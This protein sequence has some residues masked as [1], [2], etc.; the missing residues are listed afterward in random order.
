M[1]NPYYAKPIRR[2]LWFEP[3]CAVLARI[4]SFGD[5][6]LDCAS[7]RSS[8]R[9]ICAYEKQRTECYEDCFSTRHSMPPDW[10]GSYMKTIAHS[11]MD[12]CANPASV[13]V[14]R[15]VSV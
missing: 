5:E 8:R 15:T 11:R 14:L 3:E 10:Q 4:A 2:C 6:L 1:E 9:D 12:I 7:D 13:V